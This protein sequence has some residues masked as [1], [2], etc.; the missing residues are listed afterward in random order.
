[1]LLMG[2]DL[3]LMANQA[4]YYAALTTDTWGLDG[5]VTTYQYDAN[6][7][8]IQKVTTGPKPETDTFQYTLLKQLAVSTRIYASG[9][10]QVVETTKNTYSYDGIRV[11]SVFAS[12]V[13]G[14]LQS[15]VNKFFLIDPFN[16]TGFAQV[17]E[18]LSRHWRGPNR[19]LH[20][21]K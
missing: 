17:I 10:N 19:I 6:G 5:S 7:S 9:G 14:V 4:V 16:L 2:F 1:M 15:S 12:T 20:V 3:R 8:I 13:N 18:E 11:S 21:G